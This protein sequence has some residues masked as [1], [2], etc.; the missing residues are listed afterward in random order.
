MSKKKNKVNAT[1]S[2]EIKAEEMESKSSM[3]S[4]SGFKIKERQNSRNNIQK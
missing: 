1:L 2:G 4:N 3:N